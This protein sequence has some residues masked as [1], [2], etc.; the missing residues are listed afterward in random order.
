MEPR[1][2]P[3]SILSVG[4]A[5]FSLAAGAAGFQVTRTGDLTPAVGIGYSVTDGTATSGTNYTSSAPTGVLDFA[6]GQTTATIPLS[7]LTTN[8]SGASRGFTVDLTGVVATFGPPAAFAAQRTFTVGVHPFSVVEADLNGD[9]RPDLVVANFGSNTVSVL[10]NTTAPGAAIASFA[11]QQT[12]AT[13]NG[14]FTVTVANVNGDGRPDFVVANSGSST[15]SV[16]LNTTAAG[17]TTASFA[18]QQTFATGAGPVSVTAADVNGDGRP[19]LIVADEGANEVSVLMNTTAPGAATATFAAQQT[20]ATGGAPRAV[21]AADV[22]GDGR[23]DL[24]VADYGSAAVS[25]LLNTTAPGAA[26]AS[27]AAGASFATGTSPSSVAV[28]DLNGDG[29]A[30]IVV[31]NYGSASVSVLLNTTAPGAAAPSFAAQQTL[32]TGNGPRFVAAAD[33]NG[34]GRP[35]LVVANY[36]SFNLSVLLNT[37]PPGAATLSFAAQQTFLTGN[38][39]FSIALGDLNGDGRPDIAVANYTSGNVGVL[40]NTTSHTES[41]TAGVPSPTFTAAAT[42]ATDMAPSSVAVADLNGD[43]LPD[44]IVANFTSGT[45]SVFVNTTAPGFDTSTFAAE[46]TF[47]VASSPSSVAVADVNGD[48]RPDLVV[49]HEGNSTVSVLL[50]TTAPGSGT[51]SFAA[52]QTFATGGAPDSVAVADVNGDGKPDLI[53]ANLG[54]NTVSVL[55]N[56][57]AAG[58]LTAGFAAQ[59]TFA[60]GRRP[61]SVEFADLNGDGKPDLVVVNEGS[62]TVSVLLNTTAPGATTSAFAAQQ[63]FAVGADSRTM[64]IADLNGDGRPDLI[65]VSYAS[66]AV[67]VLV[68]TTAAGATTATFAAQQTFAT[69]TGPRAVAAADVN[70]D[71]KID[72]VVANLGSGTASV[73]LNT[74]TPGAATATFAAQQTFA[75]GNIPYAVVTADVNGD[76]RP[77]IIVA[78]QYANTLSVLMSVEAVVGTSP[79]TG[80]IASAP[81]VQSIV[82]TDPNPSTAA[83]VDFTVTFSHAVSGVVAGNFVLSGTATVGA[84]IGT[85]A[86]TD[87]GTTWTVPVTTAGTGTLGLTL[88]TRTGIDDSSGNQLYNTTSDDGSTFTA[89]VGPQYTIEAGTATAVGSSVDPSTYG[90]S[91]TFTATVSDTSAGGVPTGSVDFY[92]GTSLLGAGTAP[93]GTGNA[94]TSTFTIATLPAGSYAITA[95]FTATGAFVGSASPDVTQTVN[96]APLTITADDQTKVYGAAVPPLTAS[97]TG[98]VNGDTAANLTTTAVLTTTATAGSTVAGNPY[99][100]TA[101]GAV[102]GNYTISYVPGALSVTAAP[103]T[104]TAD[105]QTKVYGAAVPPLTASYTGFVNGDTAASLTTPPALAT[106]ATSS[107]PGGSYVITVSGAADSN[108]A[109]AYA[110]GTLTVAGPPL[111]P[112]PAPVRPLIVVG[113]GAGG[114]P[115]VKVYDAATGALEFDFL[116]FDAGFRGGVTVASGDVNGDGVADI[117][118]GAGP[119]AG[120]AVAVFSGV[121]GALLSEFYAFDAGFRGGVT[122]AAGDVYGTGAAEIVVGAGPGAGPAV[123][124]FSGVTGA[125]L[126]EFYAFDAGFRGGVTVAAGDVYGTAAAEVVVG[127]GPRRAGPAVAVFSGVTVR[128]CPSSTRSTRVSGAG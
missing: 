93:S 97:Y 61:Y 110:A 70:G 49:T 117:I 64:T 23:P 60:T 77:D 128:C 114:L 43:G 3:A 35:D 91:V 71:G 19:D 78:N 58:S 104:I 55:L 62:A 84:G 20:F 89:V 115:E 106:T 103:L 24:I 95:V 51:I 123:A 85:P 28:A 100:I 56:T 30:D 63:T 10:L 33:V 59:Q 42:P 44:L 53:V 22:N 57:T 82:L 1:V 32:A 46:Q 38:G 127:A 5:T 2:V 31:A 108:Y 36:N 34:D 125:L 18:A 99:A 112:P 75:T 27:Y 12:F 113:A 7:I 101:S 105:N 39:P 120:P 13:G 26:T 4:N 92:N 68:N 29:R 16:L 74:T 109:F 118:V 41:T 40:L 80:T 69:G 8:F 126:S 50:G 83:T 96:P 47:A 94:A 119:G 6:S 107:S 37:T 73:L 111:S 14:P 121:T 15:V 86:T 25:V 90:Q 116:A 81:I 52:P 76:G 88:G 11:A 45:V 17:A 122:V 87:G 66:E 124:V 67:S 98:F 79:A 21:T 102:D 48:G 72:L 54:S 9:G 65:A